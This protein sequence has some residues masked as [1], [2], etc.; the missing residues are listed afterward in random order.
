MSDNTKKVITVNY[1]LFKDNAEGELIETTEGKNPLVF[2]TGVQQMIPEF[3]KNVQDLNA[4]DEFAFGIKSE[5]AYGTRRD[6]AVIELAKDMFMHEGQI[7]EQLVVGAILPLQDKNG[8]VLPAKVVSINDATVTMDLNHP[9]A[10]Q[11][12]Y[13]VGKVEE[14][15][16]A[17]SEELEHGHAHGPNTPQ[18]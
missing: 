6:D 13:F 17:T 12:L 16:E 4:G 14:V 18:H 8:N 11:D 3:E 2:L 9:L 5:N 15:R 10:D 7:I 1:K